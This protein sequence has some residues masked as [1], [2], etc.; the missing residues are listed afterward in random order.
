LAISCVFTSVVFLEGPAKYLFT[1]L[2]PR[3]VCSMHHS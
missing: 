1:P 2:G 3:K